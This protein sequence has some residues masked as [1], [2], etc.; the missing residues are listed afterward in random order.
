MSIRLVPA[1]EGGGDIAVSWSRAE[2]PWGISKFVSGAVVESELIE[3]GF[4]WDEY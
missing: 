1:L 2:E 4:S 3:K